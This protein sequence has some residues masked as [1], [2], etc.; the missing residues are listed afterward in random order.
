MKFYDCLFIS[1]TYIVVICHYFG[2]YACYAYISNFYI[3]CLFMIFIFSSIL[4]FISHY[5][6]IKTDPGK[7]T[8]KNNQAMIDFH[9]KVH[10]NS[11][12][13][14]LVKQAV[15]NKFFI[16]PNPESDFDSDDSDYSQDSFKYE[17]LSGEF[18]NDFF[19]KLNDKYELQGYEFHKN[20]TFCKVRKIPFSL[21]CSECKG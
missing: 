2:S 6:T 13:R 21:H 4:F 1:I 14:A 10:I 12:K 3:S 8:H 17:D 18:P 11:V 9:L 16:P 7:I 5:K 19:K 20:C 15:N